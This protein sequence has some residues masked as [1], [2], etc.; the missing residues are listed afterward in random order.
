MQD[1]EH[2]WHFDIFGFVEATKGSSL[3]MLFF[4]LMKQSGMIQDFHLDESKLCKY[5]QKIESGYD[6][7]NPYHNR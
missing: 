3:S 2:N 7:N 4:H 1:A 6:S 5:V